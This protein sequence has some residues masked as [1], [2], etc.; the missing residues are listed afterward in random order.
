[1]CVHDVFATSLSNFACHDT[2]SYYDINPT[3]PFINYCA[4]S[5]FC[6]HGM[7][8]TIYDTLIVSSLK[9]VNSI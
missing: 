5:A 1:M 2:V 7:H 3:S 4:T 9:G 6:Q 8:D